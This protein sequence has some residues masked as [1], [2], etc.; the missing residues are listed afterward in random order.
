[1]TG[2]RVRISPAASVELVCREGDAEVDCRLLFLGSNL[3]RVRRAYEEAVRLFSEVKESGRLLSRLRTSAEIERL[4]ESIE[5]D[6]NVSLVMRDSVF[7]AQGP[8]DGLE[9]RLRIAGARRIATHPVPLR[10]LPALGTLMPLLVGR[11]SEDEI[12]ATLAGKLAPDHREWACDLLA[13]LKANRFL[14][15]G[16]FA[17][18]PRWP[19]VPPQVTFL[20][21]TSVLMQ[22]RRSA[23]LTDPILMRPLGSPKRA[24]DVF[25]L[26]L[27]AICCTHSHWDH[28]NLQTLMWFDKNTPVLIPEVRRPSGFNPPIADSLRRIG[29]TDI[30]ELRLWTPVRIDDIEIVPVPF[31]GEQDEPGAEIDHYTYLLKTDGLSVYGGVDCFR[32]DAGDMRP[33]LEQV[34]RLYRPDVAFLPVSR[35]VYHYKHGGVNAFCR[36]LDRSRLDASFQYTAG[37]DDAAAWSALLGAR[38]V[39]PYAMFTFSRWACPRQM[40]EVGN[41]L[42]ERNLGDRFYPL[43]PLDSL[44]P[45]DLAGAKA[46]ARRRM[47]VAWLDA[48]AGLS[49]IAQRAGLARA[50]RLLRRIWKSQVTVRTGE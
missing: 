29:F 33:V 20:G 43:R 1:M 41:V 46:T 2:S 6:G 14:E 34:G 7:R 19:G 30:R 50:F 37:P 17:D 45:I 23:V 42:R 4:Y 3:A 9:L 21:H 49:A 36:Y 10:F 16:R 38:A 13:V 11:H 12:K 48:I 44:A 39:T 25:R 26:R 22:S 28:C 8:V 18:Q 35:V 40:K 27:G 32:D 15:M 24:F 31:H 47:L 5:T